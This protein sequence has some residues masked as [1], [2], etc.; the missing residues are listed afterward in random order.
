MRI[1]I[2]LTRSRANWGAVCN[3]IQ[4]QQ[5]QF[6]QNIDPMIFIVDVRRGAPYDSYPTTKQS[7]SSKGGSQIG[8]WEP[9]GPEGKNPAG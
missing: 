5:I 2:I 6:H 1:S 8:I 3:T 9:E 7:F 4:T